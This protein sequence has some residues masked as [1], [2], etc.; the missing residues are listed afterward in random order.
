MP[1]LGVG[2]VCLS[3]K[4][5]ESVSHFSH[6]LTLRMVLTTHAVVI[7]DLVWDPGQTFQEPQRFGSFDIQTWIPAFAGMT[8]L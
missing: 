8:A 2:L 1:I 7:P 4:R 6:P 3:Q 5:N